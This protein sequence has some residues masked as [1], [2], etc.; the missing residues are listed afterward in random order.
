MDLDSQSKVIKAHFKKKV[1]KAA[2]SEESEQEYNGE[3]DGDDKDDLQELKA[4]E[5]KKKLQ[6]EVHALFIIIV[7]ITFD[8][9]L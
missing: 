2:E 5:I 9:F 7:D 6:S 4:M 8:Y 1:T 3:D